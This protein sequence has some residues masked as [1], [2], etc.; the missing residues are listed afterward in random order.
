V[1]RRER[2][3]ARGLER[4]GATAFM[5]NPEILANQISSKPRI[6]SK[7]HLSSVAVRGFQRIAP[8]RKLLQKFGV[9]ST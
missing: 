4:T 3:V 7:M 5:N 6:E 9:Q 2:S 1:T 8:V